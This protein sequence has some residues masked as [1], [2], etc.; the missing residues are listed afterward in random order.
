MRK[1]IAVLCFLFAGLTSGLS[2]LMEPPHR[3]IQESADV[4]SIVQTPIKEWRA[5]WI[6][7]SGLFVLAGVYLLVKDDLRS[8]PMRY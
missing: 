8:R 7:F 4:I 5:R 3:S 1:K 6:T 2:F